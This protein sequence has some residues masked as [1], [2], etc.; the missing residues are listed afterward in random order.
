MSPTCVYQAFDQ[1]EHRLY[2]GLSKHWPRR[3]AAHA[4]KTSWWHEVAQLRICQL[5]TIREAEWLEGYYIRLYKPRY[6]LHIPPW[7]SPPDTLSTSCAL[8]HTGY[9]VSWRPP[10]SRCED[11]SLKPWSEAMTNS[12]LQ[13]LACPG[14][15]ELVTQGK[16]ECLA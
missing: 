5:T 8:C 1:Q 9:S 11:L 15:C 3:W 16:W 7:R 12:E 14:R 6:N 13:A 10:G 4:E 2:V